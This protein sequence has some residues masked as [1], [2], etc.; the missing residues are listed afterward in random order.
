MCVWGGGGAD[1]EGQMIR[2]ERGSGGYKCLIQMGKT[3]CTCMPSVRSWGLESS[4]S[5]GGSSGGE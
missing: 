5:S 2:L 4:A 3:S 1:G